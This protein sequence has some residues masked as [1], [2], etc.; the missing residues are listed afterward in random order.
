MTE[1]TR[2]LATIVAL[3]VAGFSARTEADEERT[4]AQVA[5]LRPVVES[6]AKAHGGRVFNTAGDGFML[7]FASSFSAVGGPS[8]AGVSLTLGPSSASRPR[9]RPL[10]FLVTMRRL[11]PIKLRAKSG[12][13]R[14]RSLRASRPGPT[15]R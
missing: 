14:A 3:D 9:P 12:R 5:N 4:I 8:G 6:I 2:K 10:G 1:P 13:A 11:S 7:E 15:R